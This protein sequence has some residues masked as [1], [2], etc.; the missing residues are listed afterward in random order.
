MPDMTT[1]IAANRDAVEQFL[2]AAETCA[3]VWTTPRAP[4]KWSPSQLTEHVARSFEEAAHV[5]LGQPT[6][7]PNLPRFL[8]PVA[9]IL[10][11]N[12]VLK[13]GVLSNSKTT[14]AM[15]PQSGPPTFP[16][17]QERLQAALQVF[18]QAYQK[19]AGQGE[20]VESTAFGRVSLRDYAR[21]VALHTRHHMGQLPV[22]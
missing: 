2:A 12:R 14:K 11:F 8:R 13:T 16:E 20:M 19:A 15:D 21:F 9:R 18:V 5:A 3:D 7:L 4:G 1:E 10:F 17:G 22:A 6:K